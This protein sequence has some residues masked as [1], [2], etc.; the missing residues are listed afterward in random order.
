VEVEHIKRRTTRVTAQYVVQKVPVKTPTF[1]GIREQV[2][3]DPAKDHLGGRVRCLE[4]RVDGAQHGG[5]PLRVRAPVGAALLRAQ[6][7][8]IVRLVKELV[9]AD[10]GVARCHGGHHVGESV[11]MLVDD[12]AVDPRRVL[13]VGGPHRVVRKRHD[14]F[15][16]QVMGPAQGGIQI[17][18][19]VVRRVGARGSGLVRPYDGAPVDLVAHPVQPG[20]AH[21]VRGLGRAVDDAVHLRPEGMRLRHAPRER[22]GH[23]RQSQRL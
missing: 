9:I 20:L 17:R 12:G 18:V 4:G 11:Q 16:P 7:V 3:S 6:Q 22:I 19:P 8:S 1:R 15:E 2:V 13:A 10:P 5:V 21:Q 14:H 23:H